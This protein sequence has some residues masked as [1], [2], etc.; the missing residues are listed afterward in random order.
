MD[1]ELYIDMRFVKEFRPRK[2]AFYQLLD[3]DGLPMVYQRSVVTIN[4]L[5]SSYCSNS[6][7]ANITLEDVF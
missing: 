6:S 3:I 2:Y 4:T 5:N 7:V 1:K